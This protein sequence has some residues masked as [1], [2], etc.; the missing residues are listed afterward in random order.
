MGKAFNR[1]WSASLVSNLSDGVLLAAAPLL[2]ITLTDNTVLISLLGA[3]VMLP[4]LLFAIP[5]GTLVDRL[6]RRYILAGTNLLRSAVVGALAF[7]IAAD[8]VTIHF[9]ILAAFIIGTCEVASDTTAQSLIPQILE[10]KHF[11]K[12]N[13]RLQISE[14]VVQ[15]FIGAP[16]SGFLYALAIYIP[17]FFNSVGYIISA[18]L[19]LSMPI[20]FLQDVRKEE[21]KAEPKHFIAD[22]KFGISYLYNHKLL[23]RLVLTT[24][25]IGVCYSMATATIVLF[26]VRELDLPEP[27]FGLVLT[28]EGIGGLIGAVVAPH[29]SKRFGRA[30]VM[31]FGIFSSSILILLQGFAPNI[32]LFVG[33]ATFGAFTISQWNI[34]LMSTYQSLIPNEIYGRIHGTRRTLVWGMMPIGS[35]IGGVLAATGLRTPLYVGGFIATV[36]ALFSIKFMLSIGSTVNVEKK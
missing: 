32:Y 12:A 8:L 13:S 19:A 26:M 24:S 6:D 7:T 29:A 17:F 25:L 30:R 27:L 28:I 23:R 18:I 35:V 14:T 11:E 10:E 33:L 5:I 22:M 3:M 21:R 2:A 9:L 36:I 16:L 20:H 34:L 15:G 4:W 31:T 1:L